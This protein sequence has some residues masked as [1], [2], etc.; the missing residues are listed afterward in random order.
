MAANDN[1]PPRSTASNQRA[2]V[3]ALVA[4]LL[5][6]LAL[7]WAVSAIR[8]HNAVQNCIDAGRHDCVE[9][10]DRTK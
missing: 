4:V 3:A 5:I 2:N 8:Q 1:E 6:G 7:F 10:D 9:A